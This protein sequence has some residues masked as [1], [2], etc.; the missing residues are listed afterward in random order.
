MT[1]CEE[2]VGVWILS[3]CTEC[4]NTS[5]VTDVS[6]F[7]AH[8]MLSYSRLLNLASKPILDFLH[9]QAMLVRYPAL[10]C[11]SS[12]TL[13]SLTFHQNLTFVTP[14]NP[15]LGGSSYPQL[16]KHCTWGWKPSQVIIDF[17]SAGKEPHDPL[18][19]QLWLLSLIGRPRCSACNDYT[20]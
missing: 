3:R 8:L 1:K 18:P 14:Y 13:C 16:T 5:T 17:L 12:H 20:N 11:I 9:F 2:S 7:L 15:P 19:L 10:R 6:C 4:Q